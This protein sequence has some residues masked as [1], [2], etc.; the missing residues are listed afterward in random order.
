MD[1]GKIGTI[2]FGKSIAWKT[3]PHVLFQSVFVK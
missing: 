3:F 2:E 1:S